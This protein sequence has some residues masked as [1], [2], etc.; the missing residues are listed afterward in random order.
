MEFELAWPAAPP[1]ADAQRAA[2]LGAALRRAVAAA[3]DAQRSNWT[4]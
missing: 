1:P 4:L 3:L 2:G